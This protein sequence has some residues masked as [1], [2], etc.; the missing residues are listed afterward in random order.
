MSK[1]G[2][3]VKYSKFFILS[4]NFSLIILLIIL[5]NEFKING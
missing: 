5:F 2:G 1:H 4:T 3:P